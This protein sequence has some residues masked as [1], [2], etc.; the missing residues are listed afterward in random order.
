M[1]YPFDKTYSN[2]E[3]EFI[4]VNPKEEEEE[5]LKQD[6]DDVESAICAIQIDS[7]I[8][9][10][11][12]IFISENRNSKVQPEYSESTPNSYDSQDYE[13][14]PLP[15]VTEDDKYVIELSQYCLFAIT[16]CLFLCPCIS[17]IR[18]YWSPSDLT[19][20]GILFK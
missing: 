5:D 11:K 6:I 17:L 18:K 16:K 4:E 8:E 7:S 3:D 2:S 15:R 20:I 10:N 9:E 14:Y 19:K 12:K 13:D 1:P